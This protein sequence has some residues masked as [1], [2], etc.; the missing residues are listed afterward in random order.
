MHGSP[1]I[2]RAL[3]TLSKHFADVGLSTDI[4][5]ELASVQTSIQHVVARDKPERW[6]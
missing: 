6:R 3:N 1:V 4:Q 2:V 5:Q